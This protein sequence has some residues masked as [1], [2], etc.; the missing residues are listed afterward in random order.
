M[1]DEDYQHPAALPLCWVAVGVVMVLI[2]IKDAFGADWVSI[3]VALA[4]VFI[5]GVGGLDL[6]KRWGRRRS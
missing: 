6:F 2:N 1:S 3:S 4:G 5:A